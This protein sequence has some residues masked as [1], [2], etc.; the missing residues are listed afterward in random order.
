MAPACRRLNCD[1]AASFST[2][3]NE[4]RSLT[5]RRT[6]WPVS[7][8]ERCSNG[9]P[10]IERHGGCSGTCPMKEAGHGHSPSTSFG[11]AT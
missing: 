10:I 3:R 4:R 1:R 6:P 11:V 8:C 7:V 5:R 9:N 2:S